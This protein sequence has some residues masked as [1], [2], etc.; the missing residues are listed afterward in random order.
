MELK[1]RKQLNQKK[2]DHKI[3]DEINNINTIINKNREMGDG[4]NILEKLIKLSSDAEFSK[5]QIYIEYRFLYNR[6]EALNLI[7]YS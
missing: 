1:L 4:Q 2:R 5:K 3:N 7:D 6:L